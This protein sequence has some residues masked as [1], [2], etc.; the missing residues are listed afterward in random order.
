M[1]IIRAFEALAAREDEEIDLAQAALLIASIAYP[2]LDQAQYLTRLDELARR[3][4]RLLALPDPELAP[5]LPEDIEPLTILEALNT[6]LF[7][8]EKFRGNQ[9][10]YYN[11]NNSFLNKVLETHTGI[12]IT[13]SLLY[14]EVGRR[15]GIQ[16]DGIGF[17][18]HFMVRHQ[19]ENSVVYIDPFS[20]G[21]LL[22]EQDCEARLHQ[23]AQHRVK[24]H[25][26]WFEPIT[27]R[28]MLIRVLNNLKRIYIDKENYEYALAIC[29]LIVLLLPQ[30]AAER[31]DR[32]LMHLQLKH[33]GKALQDLNTYLEQAPQSEDRYEIR[34]HIKTIRQ[35]LALLN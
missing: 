13:L 29:D 2:D 20:G 8:D 1:R 17:P 31:R 11:P 3:V 32:G 34:N 7:E 28:H 23:I 6:V 27:H 19:W 22:N 16:I 25:A 24:L 4:R 12:P 26:Q 33:Y 18:Y 15:V 21:T 35:A 30:A 10:D 9:D 14:I 5:R